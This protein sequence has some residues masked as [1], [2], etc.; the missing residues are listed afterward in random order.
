MN[1]KR[2]L[3][4]LGALTLALAQSAAA[5]TYPAKS[6]RFINPYPPGGGTDTF[7]RILAQRMSETLGQQVYVDNRGGAQGSVGT[8]VAA[9]AP[10]D[11]YTIVLAH[12]G[13]LSINP[14]LYKNVG[15]DALKDFL[16]V[17][18]GSQQGYLVVVHPSVPAKTLKEL[19]TVA[20][21][22]PGKLSFGSSSSVAQ[23]IGELFKLVT[24]TDMLHVPYKGAAPAVIDLLAGYVDLMYSTP[25]STTPHVKA[26]RLR[27]LA[28]TSPERLSALPAVPTS[29]Q[30][31]FPEFEVTG[32]YGVAVPAGTPREIVARL[33]ETIVKIMNSQE[34]KDKL[35]AAGLDSTASTPEQLG[36]LIRKDY[37]RW[38]KVVKTIG[39]KAD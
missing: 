35:D 37:E 18:L 21:A 14:H 27:A 30:A 12:S 23:L 9:K 16:P 39:M 24:K 3:T 4:L 22:Q 8:A 32:W 17:S 36:A 6:I 38:G 10:P 33:N 29:K 7:A 19:A 34:T 15:Y 5:Q 13:P 25:A 26:N 31:G 20:R 28:V 11:G 1:H 2:A